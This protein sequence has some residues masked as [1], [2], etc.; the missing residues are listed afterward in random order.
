MCVCYENYELYWL[1]T[2]FRGEASVF[3]SRIYMK[4][5]GDLSDDF[6]DC[7]VHRNMLLSTVRVYIGV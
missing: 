6:N 2:M 3:L 7:C 4:F 5:F 1:Y